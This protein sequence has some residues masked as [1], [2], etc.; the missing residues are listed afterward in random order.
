MA[1]VI[2]T[3]F[4]LRRGKAASWVKNN[5]I[6]AAGEPG[7]VS[8]EN[9]FK[10]GDGVTDWIHLPYMEYSQETAEL[11]EGGRLKQ[12]KGERKDDEK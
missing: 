10:V 12:L 7:F 6:L 9:R 3:T 2:K 8:N 1:Q 4:Q 11:L 5:P